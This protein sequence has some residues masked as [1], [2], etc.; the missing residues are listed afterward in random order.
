MAKK[1][2]ILS[3]PTTDEVNKFEMLYPMVVADLAEVKSLSNK[4]PDAP[5]NKLKV[6]LFNKKLEMIKQILTSEQTTEFLDILDVDSLPSNSDAVF[7]ILQFKT[8]M[9]Q[10]KSKY[11]TRDDDED[12]YSLDQVWSWKTKT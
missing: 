2:K 8:A 3:G 12:D 6:G 11:Y 7:I 5:L 4:K 10:F 1:G 9:D